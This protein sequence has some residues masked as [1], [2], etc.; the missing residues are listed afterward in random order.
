MYV[1]GRAA[2]ALLPSASEEA[3]LRETAAAPALRSLGARLLG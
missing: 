1:V 2:S 3:P